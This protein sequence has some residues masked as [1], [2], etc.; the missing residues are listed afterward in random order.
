MSATNSTYPKDKV[1]CSKY[2][3]VVNH[4]P[5]GGFQLRFCGKSP[6]FRVAAKRYQLQS[7]HAI[8]NTIRD[9]KGIC[10]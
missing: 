9:D 8:G 4:P 3:L 2:S 5:A 7:H 1:S 6:A 10:W